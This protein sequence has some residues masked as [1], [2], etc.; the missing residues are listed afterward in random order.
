MVTAKTLCSVL[1][2]FYSKHALGNRFTRRAAF[3]GYLPRYYVLTDVE[4]LSYPF[5][6]FI[7]IPLG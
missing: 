3:L 5:L 4:C 6:R 2:S 7:K 1:N